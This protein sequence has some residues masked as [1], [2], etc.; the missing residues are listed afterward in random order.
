M[1]G[2]FGVTPDGL[3][4]V[5]RKLREVSGAMKA[6]KSALSAELAAQGNVWGNGP[7]GH[8]FAEGPHGY[9]AQSA[10]V[11]GS[12]DAKTGL[13]DYY[14]D[15]L[16][17]AADRSEQADDSMLSSAV[18]GSLG[19]PS[20]TVSGPDAE[21]RLPIAAFWD[22]H[23]ADV[24]GEQR[25]PAAAAAPRIGS[26]A[27]PAASPLVVTGPSAGVASGGPLPWPG[28]GGPANSSGAPGEGDPAGDSL[29][30]SDA[31][32]GAP[33]AASGPADGIAAG[34]GFG[35]GRKLLDAGNASM[36]IPDSRPMTDA[37][38]PAGSS[39]APPVAPLL[40][41]NTAAPPKPRPTKA[42]AEP[43]SG[44]PSPARDRRGGVAQPCAP[45]PNGA[46][47]Q[48]GGCGGGEAGPVGGTG[49]AGVRAGRSAPPEQLGPAGARAAAMTRQHSVSDGAAR[50]GRG[51]PNPAQRDGA[52][53]D[54]PRTHGQPAI[55]D[56]DVAGMKQPSMRGSSFRQDDT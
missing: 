24:S 49:V 2:E 32:S 9:L 18:P 1:A 44:P 53:G 7:T 42:P 46:G 3:R 20:A 54:A 56:N 48:P 52:V 40:P 47:S 11:A 19:D 14:A 34:V 23:G 45:G 55:E 51:R 30:S 6:G 31:T 5:A 16:R 17:L 41:P 33:P 38:G 26:L 39:S 36:G 22:A 50:G 13:L 4:R 27:N 21:N 35:D 25:A 29:E 43:S 37:A 10:W 15:L 8:Q 28:A 12:I